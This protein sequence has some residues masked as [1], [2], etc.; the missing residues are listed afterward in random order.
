MNK[1]SMSVPEMQRMLGLGKT[2]SYWLVKKNCFETIIVAGKMRII[3]DSFEKWY[4]NHLHYK[5]VDGSL[6]GEYWTAITM[7][8][9]ETAELIGITES[10]LYDLLK[11]NLFCTTQV[12][13]QQDTGSF[14][15]PTSK[16]VSDLLE[17]YTSIYGVSTWALSTYEARSGLIFNYITPLI[18]DMQLED[19]T[20][21]TMDKFYQ[22]LLAVKAKSVNKRKPTHEFLTL[23]I[24]RE[25]HKL[26]QNAF[27]QAVKWE[28]MSRNPVI[29]AT[30]PKAEHKQRDIWTADTLFKAWRFTMMTI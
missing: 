18:R 17:E 4:A 20:P 8:V 9:R 6:P 23:H 7:S 24:V 22:S 16:T 11:K 15:V 21:R 13:F 26:L 3:V 19:V 14:N 12:E 25:I 28:L 10:S 2:D 1:K 5:K 30:L 29:N 27:N